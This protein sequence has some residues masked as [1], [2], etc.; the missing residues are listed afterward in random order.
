[1]EKNADHLCGCDGCGRRGSTSEGTENFVIAE[2][3]IA[4]KVPISETYSETSNDVQ[5][6]SIHIFCGINIRD[7]C[8]THLMPAHIF[9][10]TYHATDIICLWQ[11]ANALISHTCRL[12]FFSDIN[13]PKKP[14]LLKISPL[15]ACSSSQCAR[16]SVSYQE[17]R[18]N[19]N[20]IYKNSVIKFWRR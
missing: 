13:G 4:S 6:R 1:M 20:R 5:I 18:G 15:E 19:V 16:Y 9:N 7:A 8:I 2:R 14:L 10:Q 11:S 17:N 12:L 3:N